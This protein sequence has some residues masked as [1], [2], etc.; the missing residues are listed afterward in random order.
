MHNDLSALISFSHGV[1][2]PKPKRMQAAI[3]ASN[4]R[5][6]VKKK[7]EKNNTCLQDRHPS[8]T[9]CC[10]MQELQEELAQL[11]Y[12]REDFDWAVAVLHSRCFVEGPNRMHMVVPGVDMANH[13][14]M[15]NAAVRSEVFQIIA[16]LAG[17]TTHK[18]I[19]HI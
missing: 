18:V 3:H 12:G 7:K 19:M 9:A 6:H 1:S 15:P 11:G 14:F 8:R 17:G 16:D 13:S 10:A 5:A 4:E 2:L